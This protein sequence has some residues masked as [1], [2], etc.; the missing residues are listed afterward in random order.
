LDFQEESEV[1]TGN[2]P[3]VRH[4]TF[5]GLLGH[6]AVTASK[7]IGEHVLFEAGLEV[8]YALTG[9]WRDNTTAPVR[10]QP[11]SGAVLLGF[12]ID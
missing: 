1:V 8:R 7:Q 2:L 9:T 10:G 5:Q 4:Q 11:W 12:G 3:L 6:I